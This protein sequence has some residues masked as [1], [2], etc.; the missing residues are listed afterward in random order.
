M[1][2]KIKFDIGIKLMQFQKNWDQ[3]ETK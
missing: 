2:L 3:I 1:Y